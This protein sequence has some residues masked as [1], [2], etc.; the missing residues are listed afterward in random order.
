MNALVDTSVWSL[1]L[2][3]NPE[4][5]TAV[6]QAVVRE[7]AELARDGRAR[8]IGSIRQE[9]L[10]GIK[11]S[12]QYEKLRAALR[13]FPDEM[14]DTSDHEEAAKASNACRSRGVTVSTMDALICQIALS[15][16]W[17]IFSTDPDFKNYERVL[18]IKL[19]S[20][21]DR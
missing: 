6:E 15:R 9:L 4:N 13:A 14:I 8:I 7:L 20:P 16:Q 18:P 12:A 3:R 1:A 17:S 21:R 19:H 5:V 11:S 10:S 2:R